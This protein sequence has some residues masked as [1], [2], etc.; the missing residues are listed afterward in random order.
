VMGLR[1]GC[2]H[3]FWTIIT[4]D[5]IHSGDPGTIFDTAAFKPW[6]SKG[7]RSPWRN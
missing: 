2:K 7:A 5:F 4:S 1:S 3:D 6:P